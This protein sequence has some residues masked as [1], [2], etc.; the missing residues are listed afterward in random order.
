M[1]PVEYCPEVT[2]P[3][4]E[5]DIMLENRADGELGIVQI[6]R[7]LVRGFFRLATVSDSH[8]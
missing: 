8:F 2:R 6:G 4:H 1:L 3:A 5:I 7:E